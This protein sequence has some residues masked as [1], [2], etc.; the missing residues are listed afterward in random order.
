M[1]SLESMRDDVAQ[2]RAALAD[3]QHTRTVAAAR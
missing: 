3:V 2:L 1:A